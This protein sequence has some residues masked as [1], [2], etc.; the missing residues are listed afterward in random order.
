MQ[1]RGTEV[2]HPKGATASANIYSLIETSKANGLEPY[3]YLRYLFQ[4]LPKTQSLEQ[5][6]SLLPFNMET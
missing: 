5:I 4:E 6:E 3:N 1:S 2:S